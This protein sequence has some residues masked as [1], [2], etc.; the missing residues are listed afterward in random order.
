MHIKIRY[1]SY[2]SATKKKLQKDFL[3]IDLYRND[4]KFEKHLFWM[5]RQHIHTSEWN[6]GGDTLQL[7]CATWHLCDNS[8]SC[9]SWIRLKHTNQN[10]NPI[11]R[12]FFEEKWAQTMVIKLISTGNFPI[13]IA[14]IQIQSISM[15]INDF[16]FFHFQYSWQHLRLEQK[17]YHAI[18][19][20]W[21]EREHSVFYAR[22]CL[23]LS[24]VWMNT[25]HDFIHR[26]NNSRA[27][28]VIK[29]SASSETWTNTKYITKTKRRS[30]ANTVTKST[31]ASRI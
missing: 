23:E 14:T 26:Q 28:N 9:K 17:I 8:K 7:N 15:F 22:K 11:W 27:M 10:N 5:Y 24:V 2:S 25:M 4:P 31:P 29:S 19:Q 13:N 21:N 1:F 16:S 18:R 12:Y 20:K 3:T 30:S 6:T